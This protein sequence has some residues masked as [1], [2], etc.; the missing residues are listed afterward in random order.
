[1]E[2]GEKKKKITSDLCFSSFFVSVFLSQ[3]DF[4]PPCMLKLGVLSISKTP[5]AHF[6]FFF[7]SPKNTFEKA[8]KE[9]V[10][11]RQRWKEGR[12]PRRSRVPRQRA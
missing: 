9:N 10:Q 4:P 5:L 1:M 12:A 8:L 6:F 11:D 2:G 7:S 3:S